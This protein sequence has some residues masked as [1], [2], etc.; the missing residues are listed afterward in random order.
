M[1]IPLVLLSAIA[2]V[3][4]A[5]PPRPVRVVS[6]E[7][8][9]D[10]SV[11]FRY[12]APA[13]QKVTVNREGGQP[14]EMRKDEGGV[15]SVTTPPLEPDMYGYTFNVDGVNVIDPVNPLMK[16]NLLNTSSM[17]AI[18]GNNPWDAADVPRGVLHHHFYRSGVV[19]DQRD[20][21]VYTPPGYSKGK[22]YPV[23]YLL[24]GFSDDASGWT[25]A[26]HAH[27]ILDNL[28]A[29]GKASPML[30][31]M[32]LG[33]G[34]PEILR[35]G[36]RD[37]ALV[38]RNYDKYREALFTEVI[39]EVEKSYRVSR[40][41]KDRAIAGLSMGGAES[42][43]VGLNNLDRFAWVG[44]FSAGGLPGATPAEAFPSLDQSANGKLKLLW[45]ACGKQD[46]LLQSNNKVDAE[47]TQRGVKHEYVLTEGAHTWLVWRRNL[48]VF[49]PL[50]FR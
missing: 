30:I 22:K 47:L 26:G 4:L 48:A 23:L 31:V 46:G 29:Q 15:W 7:V 24:H 14:L 44:S 5:Q 34:A 38:K 37:A 2:A 39:P 45:I 35:G 19:G 11:T 50:L 27:V 16:P 49:A 12:R 6:P 42:L 21:Y 1:R 20:F 43:Y 3:A 41:R 10:H 8:H 18:P 33:Y 25:A 32:T 40:D 17:V 9:P 13:A 28:L 36:F